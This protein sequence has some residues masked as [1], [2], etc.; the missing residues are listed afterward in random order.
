MLIE[1]HWRQNRNIFCRPLIVTRAQVSE[2]PRKYKKYASFLLLTIIYFLL[3]HFFTIDP[4]LKKVV[5]RGERIVRAITECDNLRCVDYICK[6]YIPLYA[7]FCKPSSI[8][9][10]LTSVV[11]DNEVVKD[12]QRPH[13]IHSAGHKNDS[14]TL[15]QRPWHFV[16]KWLYIS[17]LNQKYE[18]QYYIQLYNVI[19]TIQRYYWSVG[20][21]LKNFK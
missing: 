9:F 4:S 6:M 16:P 21:W 20:W 19:V 8:L 1:R 18:N 5:D 3:F 7:V 11:Q 17:P 13:R 10:V 15:A 2:G 14:L 12:P